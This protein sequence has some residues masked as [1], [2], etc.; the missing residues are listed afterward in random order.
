M[1]LGATVRTMSRPA[2][3]GVVGGVTMSFPFRELAPTSLR[4]HGGAHL[5]SPQLPVESREAPSGDSR[6]S[7]CRPSIRCRIDVVTTVTHR[8]L[9]VGSRFWGEN[10]ETSFRPRIVGSRGV[11]GA[12]PD[13]ADL[14]LES[15]AEARAGDGSP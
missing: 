1:S 3:A 11:S 15:V 10:R 13:K 12:R 6:V 8:R 4:P 2:D 7:R 14:P 5:C 9:L